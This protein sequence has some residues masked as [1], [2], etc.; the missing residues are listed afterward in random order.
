[1][2][3]RVM[4]PAT[5]FDIIQPLQ[6]NVQLFEECE[7]PDDD[8][9]YES[10]RRKIREE[11]EYKKAHVK[12]VK[13]FDY[14][15]I[16]A[17]FFSDYM[18]TVKE[19][20]LVQ[21]SDNRIVL[22][23]Q[24]V[25]PSEQ[26]DDEYDSPKFNYKYCYL[27]SIVLTDITMGDSTTSFSVEDAMIVHN[28][29]IIFIIKIS[30]A[31]RA[32]SMF[33]GNS[34]RQSMDQVVKDHVQVNYKLQVWDIKMD[35]KEKKIL[36]LKNLITFNLDEKSMQETMRYWRQRTVVDLNLLDLYI[37][38]YKDGCHFSKIKQVHKISM[39]DVYH[40][41]T[42][43]GGQR[44]LSLSSQ[45]VENLSLSPSH[46]MDFVA[47]HYEAEKGQRKRIKAANTARSGLLYSQL[48]VHQNYLFI[49]HGKF[50]TVLDTHDLTKRQH[51]FYRPTCGE[52]KDK[53]VLQKSPFKMKY[54]VQNVFIIDKEATDV[55]HRWK[56]VVLYKSGA[57]QCLRPLSSLTKA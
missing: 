14:S 2:R 55:S 43:S 28:S 50:L 20:I 40:K 26:G 30:K 6:Y 4:N 29:K 17:P 3:T 27:G 24:G 49:A 47:H 16:E 15:N 53:T 48:L 25:Q 13:V 33:E 5:D 37:P 57:L 52:F 9:V 35:D 56:V 7:A 32:P 10:F 45:N 31:V 8:E 19:C 18:D 54:D 21:D 39:E 22:L 12:C 51:L 41:D 1:M 23:K 46:I 36:E 34:N 38:E 11:H 44:F 42:S